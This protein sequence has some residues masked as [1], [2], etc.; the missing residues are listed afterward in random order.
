[1]DHNPIPMDHVIIGGR[2]FNRVGGVLVDA[3]TGE[4]IQCAAYGSNIVPPV[5]PDPE[6]PKHEFDNW[7]QCMIAKCGGRQ[8]SSVSSDRHAPGIQTFIDHGPVIIKPDE[9]ERPKAPH[10]PPDDGCPF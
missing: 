10:L 5:D 7:V 2:T 6:V 9:T 1:M 4:S 8:P 3:I